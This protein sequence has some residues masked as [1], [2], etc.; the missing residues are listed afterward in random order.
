[1]VRILGYFRVMYGS[2]M[3][4]QW[5]RL[6]EMDHTKLTPTMRAKLLDDSFQL[7]FSGR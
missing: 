5:A 2:E 6:L 3:L 4:H 7:A 1:M